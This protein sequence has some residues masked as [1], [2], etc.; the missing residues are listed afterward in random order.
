MK[1]KE[2]LPNE[3]RRIASKVFH[4][5]RLT[6]REKAKFRRAVNSNKYHL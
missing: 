1:L 6:T 4:G 3:L 5:K 2:E